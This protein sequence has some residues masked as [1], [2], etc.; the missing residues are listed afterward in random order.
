MV[1]T[2]FFLGRDFLPEEGRSAGTASSYDHSALDGAFRSDRDIIGKPPP[3]RE[4]YT[5]VG[6]LAAVPARSSRKP[7]FV[8]LAF[9]PRT[10][11]SRIFIYSSDG[12]PKTGSH[13]PTGQR[14]HGVR[15]LHIAEVYQSQ[16]RDG[17]PP[18]NPCRMTSSARKPSRISGCSVGAVGLHPVDRLA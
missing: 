7:L 1:G 4:R 18:S 9:K 16:T 5:V 8:P 13:P 6:V 12:P 10:D 15:H 2:P 14:G 11:Q 3:Q 17:A